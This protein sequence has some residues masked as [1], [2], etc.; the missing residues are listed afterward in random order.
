MLSARDLTILGGST[1]GV[2]VLA[3]LQDY[4]KDWSQDNIITVVFVCGA[5]TNLQGAA[6]W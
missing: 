2:Q 1:C 6:A 5:S 4:A 3:A